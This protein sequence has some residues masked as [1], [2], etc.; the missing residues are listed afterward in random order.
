LSA[1]AE[2]CIL[3]QV[4]LAGTEAALHD[5]RAEPAR[6]EPVNLPANGAGVDDETWLHNLR[7]G[8]HSSWFSQAIKDLSGH[9]SLE[10]LQRGINRVPG[11]AADAVCDHSRI[12]Q[13]WVV[14]TCR[15][16]RY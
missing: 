11:M 7:A 16:D 4:F 9:H 12:E 8:E 15:V 14:K 3:L 6:A 10:L 1:E 5:F 13:A 2:R